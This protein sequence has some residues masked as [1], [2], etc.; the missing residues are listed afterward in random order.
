M[1]NLEAELL[2]EYEQ[3]FRKYRNFFAS[4]FYDSTLFYHDTPTPMKIAEPPPKFHSYHESTW[5][6]TQLWV[7]L[8]RMHLHLQLNW[9]GVTVQ[10]LTKHQSQVSTSTLLHTATP[11]TSL[12]IN[13]HVYA[14]RTN[15]GTT[16][17]PITPLRQPRD[18]L[19][20]PATTLEHTYDTVSLSL[21]AHSH[22]HYHSCQRRITG[23]SC[24]HC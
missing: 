18:G 1:C 13:H 14:G 20:T 2:K 17:P 7:R 21:L 19:T 8:Q 10:C 22:Y 11:K 16:L 4:T 9:G 5:Q 3:Y 15:R 12:V 23:S 24:R 6:G